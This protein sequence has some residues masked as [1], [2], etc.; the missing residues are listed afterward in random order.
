MYRQRFRILETLA[1]WPW[2]RAINPHY[3]EVKAESS[4]WLEGF[5]AFNP[6]AQAS[7][8]SCDFNLLASLAY[9]LARKDYLRTGCDLMNLFFVIDEY[10][11]AEDELHAAMIANINDG[12]S[13]ESIQTTTSRGINYRRNGSSVRLFSLICSYPTSFTYFAKLVTSGREDAGEGTVTRFIRT[14]GEFF[15]AIVIQS[16]DLTKFVTPGLESYIHVRRDTSG[17]KPC[18]QLTEY[19]GQYD[20][21]EVVNHPLLQKMEQSTNDLA[22]WSN[23]IFS[24]DKKQ[25]RDDTHNMISVVMHY[26]NYGLQE[27]VDFVG[28]M[29]SQAMKNFNADREKL[30]SFGPEIDDM[31]QNYGQGLQDWIIGSLHWSFHIERYF[32]KHGPEVKIHRTVCL[33]AAKAPLN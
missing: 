25:I 24:Y 20:L 10:T 2:P 18:F 12:R 27:A 31:V 30:P 21:P 4:A 22:T 28:Q 9:P 6:E 11:D 23:D 29:R 15:D 26:Y 1:T 16:D 14:M 13:Q 17:C 8:N 7:F 19:A 3:C 33:S 5:K 32:G